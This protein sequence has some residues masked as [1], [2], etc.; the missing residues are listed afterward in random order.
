M[1]V[2]AGNLPGACGATV[3]HS[4]HTYQL[5]SSDFESSNDDCFVMGS[6]PAC[7]Y[8]LLVSTTETKEPTVANGTVSNSC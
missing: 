2:F 5:Y 6:L 4:V 1:S 3:A 8:T 7:D